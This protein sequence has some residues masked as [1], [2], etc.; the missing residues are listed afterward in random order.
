MNQKERGAGYRESMREKD[1]ELT[2]PIATCEVSH[3]SGTPQAKDKYT[4]TPDQEAR[5]TRVSGKD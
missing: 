5:E 1:G 3:S 4:W 2:S